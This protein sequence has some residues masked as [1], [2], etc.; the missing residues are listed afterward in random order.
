VTLRLP[1]HV[2]AHFRQQ[3]PGWQTR[4]IA[5]LERMVEEANRQERE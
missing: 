4:A 5:A 3:G 2:I 1:A